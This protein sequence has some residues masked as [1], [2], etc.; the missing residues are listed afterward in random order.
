MC[1]Q[2]GKV[3]KE[4]NCI[5]EVSAGDNKWEKVTVTVDS[6]AVDSVGP[7]TMAKDIRVKETPASR[8]G[9]KY[10]AAKLPIRVRRQFRK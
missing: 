6:G 10:R 9:M 7:P 2:P 8:A 3:G 1:R 4:V 5:S